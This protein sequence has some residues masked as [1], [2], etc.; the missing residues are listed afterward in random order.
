MART[1]YLQGQLQKRSPYRAMDNE[2]EIF[3]RAITKSITL[4]G[5]ETNKSDSQL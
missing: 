3:T 1:K 4:Q 5:D 2:D